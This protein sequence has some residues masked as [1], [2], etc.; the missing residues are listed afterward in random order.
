MVKSAVVVDTTM[1]LRRAAVFVC[2]YSVYTF[3]TSILYKFRRRDIFT[4]KVCC[5]VCFAMRACVHKS[6][7][8][9]LPHDEEDVL[10]IST[11]YY[12]YYTIY[13]QID[14]PSQTNNKKNCAICIDFWQTTTLSSPPI[15]T[16]AQFRAQPKLHQQQLYC[17]RASNAP[18]ARALHTQ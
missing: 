10:Y 7:F 11:N 17:M 3:I 1:T 12:Y 14:G 6:R 2:V 4:R 13:P 5:A 15:A 9:R 18:R 8:L 16:T